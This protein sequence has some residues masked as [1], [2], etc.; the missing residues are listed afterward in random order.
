MRWRVGACGGGAGAG[1]GG[2]AAEQFRG[3]WQVVL[4]AL[5]LSQ[6]QTGG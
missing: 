6:A 2:I 5:D 4:Q 3:A 1:V